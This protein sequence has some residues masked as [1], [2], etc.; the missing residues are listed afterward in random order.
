MLNPDAYPEPECLETAAKNI[1]QAPNIDCFAC[2]LIDANHP[3]QLD[4]IG[5]VYHISGLH[6]R[7]GH[8]SNRSIAPTQTKEIFQHAQQQPSIG[9]LLFANS[10]V[11]TNHILL[12]QK[13]LT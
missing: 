4:G 10:V 11:L 1:S 8:G 7:H 5:D 9:H 13:M 2:T 3:T 6:W 12:T